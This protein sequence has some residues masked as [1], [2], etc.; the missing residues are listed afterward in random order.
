MKAMQIYTLQWDGYTD[1]GWWVE[2]VEMAIAQTDEVQA[3]REL[4]YA[5]WNAG[6]RPRQVRCVRAEAMT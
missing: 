2:N 6:M 5:V 3:R 4:L 1:V